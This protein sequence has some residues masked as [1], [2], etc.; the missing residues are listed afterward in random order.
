M[1]SGSRGELSRQFAVTFAMSVDISV[2]VALT[3][4]PALCALIL[5]PHEPPNR[6]FAAFNRW[7][8]R[9]TTRYTDGVIFLLRAGLCIATGHFR[10][11]VLLAPFTGT[12]VADLIAGRPPAAAALA[13]DA[14]AAAS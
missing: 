12:I 9:V 8:A 5:K 11:G 14:S 10:N 4:S 1:L 7:F 3:L 2:I 6:F 13:F